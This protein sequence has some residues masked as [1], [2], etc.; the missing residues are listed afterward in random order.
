MSSLV[1]DALHL[2]SNDNTET[3]D[4][5]IPGGGEQK[6]ITTG[7]L[8][9][10][11][12]QS[13]SLQAY[14][15]YVQVAG[16]FGVKSGSLENNFYLLPNPTN[17][18][19]ENGQVIVFNADKTSSFQTISIPQN[20]AYNPAQAAQDMASYALNNVADLNLVSPTNPGRVASLIVRDTTTTLSSNQALSVSCAGFDMELVANN[21]RCRVGDG[22]FAVFNNSPLGYYVFPSQSSPSVD[23]SYI[24]FNAN[25]FSTFEPFPSIPQNVAYNPAQAEQDMAGFAIINASDVSSADYSLQNVGQQSDQNSTD[26]A[27]LQGQVSTLQGQVSTL[28]SKVASL[29]AVILNAFGIVIP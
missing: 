3:I 12:P 23:N 2:K 28:E 11:C 10:Q 26:I 29:S 17:Q 24:K 18:V 25:G 6:I 5:Q 20:V 14:D 15:A 13:L 7:S 22:I 21:I 27:T 16:N 19:P 4:I 9:L 8:R 1:P